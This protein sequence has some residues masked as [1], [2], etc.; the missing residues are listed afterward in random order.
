[1]TSLF[2][3]LDYCVVPP[4]VVVEVPPHVADSWHLECPV[5]FELIIPAF[6][7]DTHCPRVLTSVWNC[8]SPCFLFLLNNSLL[9]SCLEA[10][11]QVLVSSLGANPF[12]TEPK[13]PCHIFLRN[14]LCSVV[15]RNSHRRWESLSEKSFWDGSPL[16]YLYY[17]M[18]RAHSTIKIL[19]S[20]P[21]LQLT[22]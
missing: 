1:M 7:Y 19:P 5:R 17:I 4:L 20:R 22:R 12:N 18:Q 16:K 2:A 13:V 3:R 6:A 10:C 14:S 15:K 8:F 9:V 11:G 21:A